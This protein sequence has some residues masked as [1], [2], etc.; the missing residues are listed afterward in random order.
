MLDR[1]KLPILL[2]ALAM[3]LLL[4]GPVLAQDIGPLGGMTPPHPPAAGDGVFVTSKDNAGNGGVGA[5]DD[6]M[7]YPDPPCIYNDDANHPIEFNIFVDGVPA[8]AGKLGLAVC[9]V[10]LSDGEV[11][12]VY[13]NGHK[14]GTL[15]QTGDE[16]CVAVIYQVP[17]KKLREGNNLVELQVD[18]DNPDDPDWCLY[19]GWGSLALEVGAE[20]V[21]EPGSIILL[22]SGLMG[23][24]G[25]AGLRLR[26]K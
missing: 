5:A 19:V 25:Y 21:P 22:A 6:D 11:D 20:F 13:L 12:D 4:V 26:K 17:L 9:D 16:E 3:A 8:S 24:A 18:V 7:G 10:D 23:M 1:R 14:L 15:P 2:A